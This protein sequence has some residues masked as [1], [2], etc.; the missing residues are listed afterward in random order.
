M[1][2]E[3]ATIIIVLEKDYDVNFIRQY[4]VDLLA[5]KKFFFELFV[6]YQSSNVNNF[7][8]NLKLDVPMTILKRQPGLPD[9]SNLGIGDKKFL[10]KNNEVEVLNTSQTNLTFLG[11]RANI[12][13]K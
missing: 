1:T 2:K 13:F 10:M 9:F 4:L 12:I 11:R 5:T 3:F 7:I 8:N 6:L